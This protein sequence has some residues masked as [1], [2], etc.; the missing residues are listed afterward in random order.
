MTGTI[1]VTD[2]IKKEFRHRGP[3]WVGIIFATI[4]GAIGG[5]SVAA[6]LIGERASKE[7][8]G[9]RVAY[10]DAAEARMGQ[11]RDVTDRLGQCL[12]ITAKNG[13][14]ASS[15]AN[16]AATAAN[17]AASAA[18]DAATALDKV[19]PSTEPKP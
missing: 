2:S 12:A 6:Y 5:Y 8:A 9:I 18:K 19:T 1:N 16:N 15:A 3:L 7:I 10:N 17:Q 4:F 14:A 11:L 13:E